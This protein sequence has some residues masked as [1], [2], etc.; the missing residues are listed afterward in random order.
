MKTHREPFWGPGN[1]R[2]I[3]WLTPA[4]QKDVWEADRLQI[5]AVLWGILA[6]VLFALAIGYPL[7]GYLL[8]H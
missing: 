7:G 4:E 6:F 3:R 2:R 1:P 5:K 8:F